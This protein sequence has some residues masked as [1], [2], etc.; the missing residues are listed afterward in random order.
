MC[1]N[2]LR[3]L[4]EEI[5]R[6]ARHCQLAEFT[7]HGPPHLASLVER[8]GTWTCADGKRLLDVLTTDEACLLSVGILMHDIGMLAQREDD[9]DEGDRT[10]YASSFAD[11]P[12]L[13]SAYTHL[14][15]TRDCEAPH[16]KSIP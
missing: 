8:V 1:R 9:L 4:L 16:E 3:E 14:S 7:E 10:R 11:L 15:Y 2:F 13:D 5:D 6:L 12:Q